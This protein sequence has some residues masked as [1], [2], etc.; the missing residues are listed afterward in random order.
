MEKIRCIKALIGGFLG[1]L[2]FTLPW[3]LIF[4]FSPIS[5]PFLAFLIAPGVNKGYR[6]FKGRVN[7]KLPRFII[8]I[9]VFILIGVYFLLLPI[10]SGSIK[11]ILEVSY[12]QAMLRETIISLV[13]AIVGIYKTVEDILYEI[14]LRY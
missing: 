5:L 9:S 10:S 8:G 1:G 4:L 13:C 11:N 2:L 7:K 12:W 3:L 6:K 14:G